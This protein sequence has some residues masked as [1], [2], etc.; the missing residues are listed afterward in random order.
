MNYKNPIEQAYKAVEKAGSLWGAKI[1]LYK[2]MWIVSDMYKEFDYIMCYNERTKLCYI[3]HKD[4]PLIFNEKPG[5]A[6]EAYVLKV[7][8][9]DSTDVEGNIQFY[10][11]VWREKYGCMPYESQILSVNAK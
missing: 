6:E 11:S 8:P 10:E 1:P 5:V 7:K 4:A 3:R 2:K 9:I